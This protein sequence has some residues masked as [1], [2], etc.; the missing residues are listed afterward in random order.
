MN[1][2]AHE[3]ELIETIIAERCPEAESFLDFDAEGLDVLST[4]LGT[5]YDVIL[6]LGP[7]FA[8][9]QSRRDLEAAF[10][11]FEK[12]AVGGTQLII[13]RPDAVHQAVLEWRAQSARFGFYAPFGELRVFGYGSFHTHEFYTGI[14][15]F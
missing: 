15:E 10:E 8:S 7:T 4:R 6:C 5:V 13:R 1:I 2:S 3:Q 14:P 11:T 9:L 12:H